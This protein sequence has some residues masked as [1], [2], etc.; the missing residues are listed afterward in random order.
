MES[1]HPACKCRRGCGLAGSVEWAG[2]EISSCE[3]YLDDSVSGIWDRRETRGWGRMR[4]ECRLPISSGL[5][6]GKMGKGPA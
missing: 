3:H 5:E 6:F 4:E 2:E 1:R